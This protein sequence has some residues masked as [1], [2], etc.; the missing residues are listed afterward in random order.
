MEFILHTKIIILSLRNIFFLDDDEMFVRN[1]WM[2]YK[3]KIDS[4]CKLSRVFNFSF[5]FGL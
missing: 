2:K 5:Y 3:F 4:I 1:H